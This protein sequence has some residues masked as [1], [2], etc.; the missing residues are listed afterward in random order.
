MQFV[1]FRLPEGGHVVVATDQREQGWSGVVTRGGGV[2]ERLQEAA[3][4]F[5]EALDPIRA[6]GRG[7]L[8]RLEGLERPPAEVRVEFGLE[9]SAKAGAIVSASGAAT[10]KVA[11][12]WRA[13]PGSPGARADGASGP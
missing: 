3:C 8:S 7:V 10:L 4:S 13:D 9:L 11:L 2:E 6:V 5:E 1:E 12:T